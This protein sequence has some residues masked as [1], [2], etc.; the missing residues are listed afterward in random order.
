MEVPF[1]CTA[2]AGVAGVMGAIQPLQ[3]SGLFRAKV[4]DLLQLF[5][6]FIEIHNVLNS[7]S[8]MECFIFFAVA[9]DMGKNVSFNVSAQDFIT[10]YH[11]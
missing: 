1:R 3:E 5:K 4:N 9:L 7:K 8:W 6:F 11:L 10:V 2:C